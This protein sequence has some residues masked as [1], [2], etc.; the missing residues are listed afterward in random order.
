[1][2]RRVST[3]PPP[4]ANEQSSDHVWWTVLAVC[5][6]AVA[7]SVNGRPLPQWLGG[8]SLTTYAVFFGE[9]GTGITLGRDLTS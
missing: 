8:L 6:A 2:V 3:L 7:L 9:I 4:G 5:V 1:M